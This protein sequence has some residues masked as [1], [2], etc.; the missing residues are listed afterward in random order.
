MKQVP[1][2]LTTKYNILFWLIYLCTQVRLC[3]N[4]SYTTEVII[5]ESGVKQENHN[6]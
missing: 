6:P 2:Y 4:G 1:V 3:V 5:V